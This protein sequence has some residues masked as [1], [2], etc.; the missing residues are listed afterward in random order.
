M[1]W[2]DIIRKKKKPIAEQEK[3]DDDTPFKDNRYGGRGMPKK[4]KRGQRTR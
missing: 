2:R 3:Y 1:S 4:H